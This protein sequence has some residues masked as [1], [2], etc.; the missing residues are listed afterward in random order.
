M[1][2]RAGGVLRRP[3]EAPLLRECNDHVLSMY[4]ECAAGDSTRRKI[5]FAGSPES[6]AVV[7]VVRRRA[8][9]RR[10]DIP[11]AAKP[12][13]QKRKAAGEQRRLPG[14]S[15]PSSG[16]VIWAAGPYA[17][18]RGDGD[19][20]PS[21]VGPQWIESSARSRTERP[22]RTQRRT[23]SSSAAR[24]GRFTRRTQSSGIGTG[25]RCRNRSAQAASCRRRRETPPSPG[26]NAAC[27]S[28]SANASSP[29]T[30]RLLAAPFPYTG[31]RMSFLNLRLLQSFINQITTALAKKKKTRGHGCVPAILSGKHFLRG[32]W[33]TRGLPRLPPRHRRKGTVQYS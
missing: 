18:D 30:G 29:T 7:V 23:A 4:K 27:G 19:W 24:K 14:H 15:T 21:R 8:S 11:P 32:R 5:F 33:R 28:P 3:E 31:R 10:C 2:R 25:Q 17:D 9:R 6:R 22:R 16:V 12:S 13:P 20:I 26:A 1:K